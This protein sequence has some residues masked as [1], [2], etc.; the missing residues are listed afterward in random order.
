IPLLRNGSLCNATVVNSVQIVVRETCAFDSIF[1]ITASGMGMHNN[2]KNTMETL[3]KTNLF[4]KLIIEVLK[5]GKITASDYC[6]RATILCDI[7]IFS[8]TSYTRSISSLNTNFNVAH[9][10][11][12]LFKNMPTCT[13][14]YV[15]FFNSGVLLR[16]LVAP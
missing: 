6:A 10:A 11:E 3:H 4:I 16:V 2:Y 7:P 15:I 12:H 14:A 5:R 8:K 1:Q 9:L 13:T